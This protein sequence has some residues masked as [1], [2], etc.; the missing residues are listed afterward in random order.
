MLEDECCPLYAPCP[1]Y[2]IHLSRLL[3]NSV[4]FISLILDF[5]QIRWHT[6]N[7][8]LAVLF[9]RTFKFFIP[10]LFPCENIYVCFYFS[11]LR[12]VWR[13][14][15]DCSRSFNQGHWD[16]VFWGLSLERNVPSKLFAW[17]SVKNDSYE[18]ESFRFPAR[19]VSSTKQECFWVFR[20]FELLKG[21]E[22]G[23]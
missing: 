1:V 5:M 19:I 23:F 13:Y 2:P 4:K 11:Q 12:I 18:N 7:S 14:H 8:L 6:I 22:W 15:G 3:S 20:K 21:W 17:I 10:E 16:P 9:A